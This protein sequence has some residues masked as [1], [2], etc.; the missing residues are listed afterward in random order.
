MEQGND[1]SIILR[2]VKKLIVQYNVGESISKFNNV[3]KNI[4]FIKHKSSTRR[5]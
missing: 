4:K 1:S 2:R 3:V 5:K